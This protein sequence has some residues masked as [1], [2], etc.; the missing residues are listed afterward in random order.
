MIFEREAIRAILLTPEQEVLLMCI[1]KP[2]GGD[3]FWVTPGGGTEAGE[4]AEAALRRELREELGLVEF[5]V[6]PRLWRRQHT[7]NWA[8]RR[9]LQREQYFVVSVA[10]F[11]P[12]MSDPV[13]AK[14]LEQFRWW[15]LGELAASREQ[16]TPLSLAEIVRGYF[17]QGAPPE[18]LGVEFLVD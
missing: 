7:F 15:S 14:V 18:P 11:E 4:S 5:S 16:L 6:G 12:V 1:R 8:D 13:E 9:I 3:R 17:E 2:R 10:R